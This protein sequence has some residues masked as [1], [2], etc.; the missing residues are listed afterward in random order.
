MVYYVIRSYMAILLLP[1]I[2]KLEQAQDGELRAVCSNL[3]PKSSCSAQLCPEVSAQ[4][5]C[6][7]QF[8]HP[9]FPVEALLLFT[10]L[11]ETSALF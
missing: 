2:T 5:T 10:K 9:G 6:V 1:F 8:M 3:T 7:P 4:L 11:L